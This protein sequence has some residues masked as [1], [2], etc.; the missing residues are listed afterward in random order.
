MCFTNL[1]TQRRQ[2]LY[3]VDGVQRRGQAEHWLGAGA[4]GLQGDLGAA[5]GEPAD[6]AGHE[7]KVSVK[8]VSSNA[9][10]GVHENCQVKFLGIITGR[11]WNKQGFSDLVHQ[12]RYK[13]GSEI[14]KGPV[15]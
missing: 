1:R 6:E 8:D 12:A 9:A 14:K 11:D 10:G 15:I 2:S 3:L 13:G 5:Q 4:E 7:L